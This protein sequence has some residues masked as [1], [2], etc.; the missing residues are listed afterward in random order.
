MKILERKNHLGMSIGLGAVFAL[1]LPVLFIMSLLPHTAVI[2]P[3]LML[4]LFFKAGPVCTGVVSLLFIAHGW[5]NYG[6]FG[7]GYG[8]VS[9]LVPVLL[10]FWLVEKKKGFWLSVIIAASVFWVIEYLTM[11][12]LSQIFGSDVVSYLITS[13]SRT[14]EDPLFQSSLRKALSGSDM[15]VLGMFQST[16]TMREMLQ[17]M[18]QFLRIDIP[19]RIL[20]NGLVFGAAGQYYTRG[21]L[22]DI[23]PD[24]D[25][26]GFTTWAVPREWGIV[27]LS[28]LGVLFVFSR[29]DEQ[30][31][32]NLFLV[33]LSVAEQLMICQGLAA[34]AYL[35]IHRREKA[36]QGSRGRR[37]LYVLLGIGYFVI[38]L[39]YLIIGILDQTIDITHR[40]RALDEKPRP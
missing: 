33:A 4:V 27:I 35:F 21:R 36:A 17:Y 28:T 25:R 5:L 1:F 11:Y 26:P 40:R 20:T 39:P 14:L 24:V 31:Y 3:L 6:G 29:I 30:F 23:L 38:S 7:L 37:L 10:T 32:G 22:R 12:V 2:M 9:V 13:V 15:S 16:E 8:A 19:V 34:F 18:D